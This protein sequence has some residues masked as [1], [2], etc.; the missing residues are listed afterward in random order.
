[1]AG[2]RKECQGKSVAKGLQE[3]REWPP[4]H[5]LPSE[6][7]RAYYK[8]GNFLFYFLFVSNELS[9]AL[10]SLGLKNFSRFEKALDFYINLRFIIYQITFKNLISRAQGGS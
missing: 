4:K 9:L 8:L 10:K 1:M 3:A 2:A 5:S 7:V 6:T